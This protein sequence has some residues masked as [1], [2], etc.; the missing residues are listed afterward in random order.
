MVGGVVVLQSGEEEA[1]ED[2]NADAAKVLF[3]LLFV[4]RS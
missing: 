1:D 3:M 4:L 2:D